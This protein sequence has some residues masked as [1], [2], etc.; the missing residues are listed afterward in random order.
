MKMMRC[1]SVCFALILSV[2]CVYLSIFVLLH[3]SINQ[4]VIQIIMNSGK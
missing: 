4:V 2:D 3:Y 1:F